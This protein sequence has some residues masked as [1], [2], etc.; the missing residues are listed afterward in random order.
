MGSSPTGSMGLLQEGQNS[1]PVGAGKA[2][3]RPMTQ[4]AGSSKI[5][6]WAGGCTWRGG[7]HAPSPLPSPSP[8]P[9]CEVAAFPRGG[10]KQLLCNVG[11][12]RGRGGKLLHCHRMLYGSLSVFNEDVHHD[13][14]KVTCARMS[15][16]GVEPGLSRPRR[17]VLTTRR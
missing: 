6:G 8:S 12:G 1:L 5:V 3:H 10:P 13:N 11:K 14:Q 2:Q 7:G 16:P 9:N 17:D 15:S 4:R